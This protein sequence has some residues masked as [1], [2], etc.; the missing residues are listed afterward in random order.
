MSNSKNFELYQI[1]KYPIVLDKIL[2]QNFS[3]L[4]KKDFELYIRFSCIIFCVKMTRSS[5]K[6]LN[7][8]KFF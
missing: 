1:F 5:Q 4:D 6:F 7:Y 3:K 8:I 2:R